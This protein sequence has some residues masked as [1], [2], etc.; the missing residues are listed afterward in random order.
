MG[1]VAG[2]SSPTRAASDYLISGE[3]RRGEERPAAGQGRPAAARPGAV[4]GPRR[5][6]ARTS[7]PSTG[8]ACCADWTPCRC[9]PPA[10]KTCPGVAPRPAPA[11]ARPAG[12]AA[13]RGGARP[14]RGRALKIN[15]P[16]V[17]TAGGRRGCAA[18]CPSSMTADGAASQPGRGIY[19]AGQRRLLLRDP[20]AEHA[21]EALLRQLGFRSPAYY[22][23]RSWNWPREPA[24]RRARPAERGLARRGRGQALPPAR[25]VQ[26]S[27][28]APASTGSSCTAASTSAAQTR[29][30]AASCSRRCAAARTRCGS[31]T[32]RFGMLP[33][34]WLQEVRPARR[35]GQGRGRPPP[36]QRSAGRRCSTRCWRRSR[37][38]TLRRSVSRRRATSCAASTG[39]AAGRRRRPASSATLRDYQREG[40]GWLHFLR[41]FGFGGCLADDMGL[42]KT[43]QVLALLES[44]AR[45]ATSDR[46]RRRRSSSCRGRWSSTG[47]RRRRASRRSCACSTTPASAAASRRDALRRLRPVLTTYGT[48]R[49]DA[50]LLQGRRASTTCILD[51][52]QAIK[53]ADTRV[54]QG[55]AAAARPTTAWR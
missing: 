54:G 3:L 22:A 10:R 42:G 4:G 43:V 32:A 50:L 46:P 29:R 25:R 52:A 5:R 31:T 47:S 33:E 21:A 13:L 24:D 23:Q 41:S 39:V 26:A 49:R 45:R 15:P 51:E 2:S 12:G 36:L 38:S 28:S 7:A 35:H 48:L 8:S 37:R 9:R 6:A 1:V 11:P 27:R 19:Q 16:R 18:S 20:E 55:G 30:A 34:E 40:L 17:R 44:R 53:N 14:G